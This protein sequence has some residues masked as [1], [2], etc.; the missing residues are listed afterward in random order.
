MLKTTTHIPTT[1]NRARVVVDEIV[2]LGSRC[3]HLPPALEM[4]N[5]GRLDV[6]LFIEKT[7]PFRELPAAL[8][9]ACREGALKV[10]LSFT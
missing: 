10:L 8:K 1:L 7:Y 5:Q 2:I 9:H 6:R 4:L 3:G